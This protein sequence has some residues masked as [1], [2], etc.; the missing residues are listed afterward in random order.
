MP[1]LPDSVPVLRI[2]G[3]PLPSSGVAPALPLRLQSALLG[4]MDAVRPGRER[5]AAD[6]TCGHYRHVCVVSLRAQLGAELGP[7]R[8]RGAVQ[9][10]RVLVPIDCDNRWVPMFTPALVVLLAVLGCPRR[11]FVWATLERTTAVVRRCGPLPDQWVAV[12]APSLVVRSA[13]A[14]RR[15]P[16]RAV[17]G[18]ADPAIDPHRVCERVTTVAPVAVVFFTPAAPVVAAVAVRDAAPALASRPLQIVKRP[19]L[20]KDRPISL[21]NHALA[22]LASPGM[23]ARHPR[24]PS[25]VGQR[26]DLATG[27][28]SLGATFVHIDSYKVGHSRGVASAAGA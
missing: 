7:E 1:M 22:G 21:P 14:T 11:R 17:A 10:L 3:Q 25:E 15:G 18:G 13:P 23:P 28:A 2:V 20:P 8:R 9:A 5:G 27:A 6:L 19:R 26:L 4:A 12:H 16:L 24:V